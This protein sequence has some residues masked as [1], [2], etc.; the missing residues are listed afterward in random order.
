MPKAERALVESRIYG[1]ETH[2]YLP[3]PFRTAHAEH[4]FHAL[5]QRLRDWVRQTLA[6]FPSI[7]TGALSTMYDG[8]ATPVAHMTRAQCRNGNL[9]ETERRETEYSE[10]ELM[11]QQHELLCVRVRVHEPPSPKDATIHVACVCPQTLLQLEA[12]FGSDDEH[13][14]TGGWQHEQDMEVP[15]Y[16]REQHD[17]YE[18]ML[19]V[20]GEEVRGA[21]WI[22]IAIV[23]SRPHLRSITRYY[24]AGLPVKRV[25]HHIYKCLRMVVGDNPAFETG[26]RLWT[27]A[28]NLTYLPSHMALSEAMH[29]SPLPY[30]VRHYNLAFSLSLHLCVSLFHQLSSVVGIGTSCPRS[31]G[32]HT[33]VG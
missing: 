16:L 5:E 1:P 27:G 14:H 15:A 11:H 31:V 17:T 12:G 23:P 4:W 13:L 3:Y 28:C 30:T 9:R 33:H 7:T 29:S 24:Q 20:A 25:V 32:R 18:H 6:R 19:D 8:D 22:K 10:M 21:D 2:R 26:S